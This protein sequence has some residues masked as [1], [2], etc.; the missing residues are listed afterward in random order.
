MY[1]PSLTC[2]AMWQCKGQTP[3]LSATK[4]IT[5]SY[6]SPIFCDDVLVFGIITIDGLEILAYKC[7]S[8]LK[9]FRDDFHHFVVACYCQSQSLSLILWVTNLLVL[10]R[11]LPLSK[12]HRPRLLHLP[13][14]LQTQMVYLR[15]HLPDSPGC[16]RR[17]IRRSHRKRGI[18]SRHCHHSFRSLL[19]S[20]HTGH[21]LLPIL[22]LCLK[23]QVVSDKSRSLYR[24][25]SED[26]EMG[27]FHL[28]LV[29]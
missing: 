15:R 19:P 3:G 23:G 25:A 21:L 20:R 14:S 6:V 12:S 26:T 5:S 16:W 13:L 18:R 11:Y 22:G 4:S 10:C 17:L 27:G 1:K 2:H 7:T 9:F 8:T 28:L 29:S 24:S